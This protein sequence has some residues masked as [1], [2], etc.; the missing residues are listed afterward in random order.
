MR[1]TWLLWLGVSGA[2]GAFVSVCLRHEMTLWPARTRLD[3]TQTVLRPGLLGG[4]A[5]GFG[6]AVVLGAALLLDPPSLAAWGGAAAAV[7]FCVAAY[8]AG[9]ADNRLLRAAACRLVRSP[10]APPDIAERLRVL[11]AYEL[12]RA[13]DDLTPRF[14]AFTPRAP[15]ERRR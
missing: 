12:F 13:A 14:D 10:A 2:V 8:V 15:E 11:T 1:I 3:R 5:I 7:G 6:S 4:L 9:R